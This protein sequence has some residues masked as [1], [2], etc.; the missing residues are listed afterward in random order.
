[1][2]LNAQHND[3]GIYGVKQTDKGA[4]VWLDGEILSRNGFKRGVAYRRTIDP[5]ANVIRLIA[6]PEGSYIVSGKNKRGIECPVIDLQSNRIRDI[7]NGM[8]EVH[9]VFSDGIIQI[10]ISEMAARQ[11]ERE[12]RLITELQNGELSESTLCIGGG[13]A[14]LAIKEGFENQGYNISTKWVVDRESKYLDCATRNNR[15]ITRKTKIIKSSLECVEPSMIEPTSI[16]QLSLP[17]TGHSLSGRA[18]L[19]LKEAESHSDTTS[20]YGFLRLLSS[21]NAAVYISENVKQAQDSATYILI[22]QTLALLGYRITE[23]ILDSSQSGSLENRERYW[24]V[25]VSS[26]L[27][28]ADWSLIPTYARKYLNIGEALDPIDDKDPMWSDNNYLKAKSVRDAEDGKGFAKRQLVLPSVENVGVINRLY[29][30]RQSTP[31]MLVREIDD[32]ERLFT[33]PEQA[34]FKSCDPALVKDESFTTATEILGQG[35]DMGQGRGIAEMI[36]RSVFSNIK[37]NSNSQNAA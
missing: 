3:H 37:I 23:G 35:I 22:K 21:I 14:T 17:C 29:H 28:V 5:K 30:K 10:S 24:F 16:C 13:M 9:A 26:G 2:N 1:M 11:I 25:A 8:D 36:A 12:E 34:R 31:P 33:A 20:V 6:D 32:K 19:G 7:T 4:R 18:K 15:A 27:P